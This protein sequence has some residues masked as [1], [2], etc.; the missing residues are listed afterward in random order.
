VQLVHAP[1]A[2]SLLMIVL[3][4]GSRDRAAGGARQADSDDLLQPS[5][6]LDVGAAPGLHHDD[7]AQA[8]LHLESG[9]RLAEQVDM[10]WSSSRGVQARITST[11]SRRSAS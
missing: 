4:G 9:H 7:R 6:L 2:K 11:C 8:I 10:F 5:E 1:A 3:L